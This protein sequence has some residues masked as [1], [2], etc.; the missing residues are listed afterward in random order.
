MSQ[1]HPL[2]GVI[3][4][5]GQ[6]RLIS[7]SEPGR[8]DS[9]AKDATK[10]DSSNNDGH[11]NLAYEDDYLQPIG[12]ISDKNGSRLPNTGFCTF[13]LPSDISNGEDEDLAIKCKP[14]SGGES[15]ISNCTTSTPDDSYENLV[16]HLMVSPRGHSL[17]IGSKKSDSSDSLKK[18]SES[19]TSP[20]KISSRDSLKRSFESLRNIGKTS[21]KIKFKRNQHGRENA[22]FDVNDI[23]LPIFE[24]TK[25]D[26]AQ[27]CETK[28]ED[29]SGAGTP[30]DVKCKSL[31]AGLPR[32][33]NYMGILP[34][35]TVIPTLELPKRP[36][37]D[38]N[39]K[40]RA[41]PELPYRQEEEWILRLH[42]K[43]KLQ[44]EYF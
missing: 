10:L 29:S 40:T 35:N 18:S 22:V 24:E 36:P 11:E 44:R 13:E 38:F 17:S 41:L 31:G 6:A 14:I 43:E 15:S 7:V 34:L 16:G 23:L 3:E 8:D 2:R 4:E 32:N 26:F 42:E 19:L 12:M 28:N 21:P 20:R 27:T 25:Q 1:S 33:G 9:R 30:S 37:P 39:P 5:Q